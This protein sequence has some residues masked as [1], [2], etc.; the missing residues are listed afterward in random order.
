M[1]IT[2]HIEGDKYQDLLQEKGGNGWP[3]LVFLDADGTVV[4]APQGRSVDSFEEAGKKA[5]KFIELEKKAA[6]GDKKALVEIVLVQVN[7]GT[8]KMSEADAKLKGVELTA[9]QK[10]QIE[11]AR[12]GA[13]VKEIYATY[14]KV[15]DQSEV[16]KA[17]E[18][19]GE[20]LLERKNAKKPVPQ[21][22]QEF[23]MY[24]FGLAN[25]AEI[26][27]DVA[28]YEESYNALKD[29]FGSNPQAKQ[30]LAK[31]AKTLEGLKK[32]GG[33]SPKPGGE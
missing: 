33:D 9:D 22:D 15:K 30:A 25:Y 6:A 5:Q 29:K 26:K 21:G 20:K 16:Q 31:M 1:H 23:Q 27:K 28:L 3:Y 18:T 8:I 13:E 32:G 17:R 14:G 7:A 19:I 2:T 24:W 4:G 10:K 11:A 12:P